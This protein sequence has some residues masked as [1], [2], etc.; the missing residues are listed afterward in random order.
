MIGSIM[1]EKSEFAGLKIMSSIDFEKKIK[2][3]MT[4]KASTMIESIVM[5]CESNGI[6]IETAAALISPRMKSEIETEAI[7][8]RMMISKKARL[9]IG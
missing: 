4:D 3:I 6:E 8:S 9:P 1:E 5:Y 2:S 7:N